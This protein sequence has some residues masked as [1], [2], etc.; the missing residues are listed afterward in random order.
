M[1][2]SVSKQGFNHQLAQYINIK[3]AQILLVEFD[4]LKGFVVK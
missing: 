1:D 2:D 3:P 4:N